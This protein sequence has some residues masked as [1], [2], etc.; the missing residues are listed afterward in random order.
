M[1][2]IDIFTDTDMERDLGNDERKCN[3][4]SILF[5][6]EGEKADS[7]TCQISCVEDSNCIAI[8]GIWKEWCIGCSTELDVTMS[9]AQAYR[10]MESG[11]DK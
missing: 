3:A 10:K 11:N 5:E 8:S 4:A 6:L 1:F 9:G 2:A 7:K